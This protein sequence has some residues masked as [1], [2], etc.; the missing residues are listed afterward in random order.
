MAS[1]CSSVIP[2][3]RLAIGSTRLPPARKITWETQR[4]RSHAE[5]TRFFDGL[6]LL[7]PG[8]VAV[9]HWRPVSE[10]EARARSA[11]WGGVARKP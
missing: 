9:Q 11:M 2:L 8:V 10:L 5:V 4:H 1:A 6:E 7:D 3:A